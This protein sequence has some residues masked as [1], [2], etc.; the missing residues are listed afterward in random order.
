MSCN[1][2]V[3]DKS[4]A[5]RKAW[6]P[7]MHSNTRVSSKHAPCCYLQTSGCMLCASLASARCGCTHS[8]LWNG[9][10]LA[11]RV[12]PSCTLHHIPIHLRQSTGA[13]PVQL[14][15]VRLISMPKTQLMVE[16]MN[17]FE[18]A[19]V[20]NRRACVCPDAFYLLYL[21]TIQ[22]VTITHYAKSVLRNTLWHWHASVLRPS[23][24][25]VKDV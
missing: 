8:A 15:S 10:C 9:V 2:N 13:W 6:W 20:C 21:L 12:H 23:V 25:S 11:R 18:I 14:G 7:R 19:R 17:G 4:I 22:L 5:P 16:R 1:W 3:L 24:L